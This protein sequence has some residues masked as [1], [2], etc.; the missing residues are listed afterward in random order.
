MGGMFLGEGLVVRPLAGE[1]EVGV[2]VV[3]E[4]DYHAT[5]LLSDPAE[6]LSPSGHEVLVELGSHSHRV[7][8]DVV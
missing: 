8:H 1:D 7:L 5:E 6:D 4:G 2:A 3:W